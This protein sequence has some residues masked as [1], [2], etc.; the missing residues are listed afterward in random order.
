MKKSDFLLLGIDKI[1]NTE[2][3]E[4]AYNDKEG[5]T[6]NLIKTF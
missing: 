3:I 5:I 4:A 6:E 2:V 1:K